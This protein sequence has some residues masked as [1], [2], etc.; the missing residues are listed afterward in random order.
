MKCDL[1]DLIGV[2]FMKIGSVALLQILNE[3]LLILPIILADA[4]EVRYK[5]STLR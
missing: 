3:F 5:G 1:I 4:G 2:T